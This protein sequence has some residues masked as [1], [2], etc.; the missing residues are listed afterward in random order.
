MAP[1]SELTLTKFE[2]SQTHQEQVLERPAK[3]LKPL[4][5]KRDFLNAALK[6]WA[7]TVKSAKIYLSISKIFEIV[8]DWWHIS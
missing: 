3:T 2:R 1:L 5:Q 8:L 4:A 7:H 6:G